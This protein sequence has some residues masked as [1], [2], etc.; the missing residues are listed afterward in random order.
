MASCF[1]AI[2]DADFTRVVLEIRV[3]ASCIAGAE[4][5]SKEP[6]IFALERPERLLAVL[7]PFLGTIG[8]A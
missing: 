7:R 6:D 1:T 8:P 3:P 2:R 4:E 5:R